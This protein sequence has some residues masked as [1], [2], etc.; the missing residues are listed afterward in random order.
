MMKFSIALLA[1]A[2]AL[3]IAPMARADTFDFTFNGGGYSASGEFTTTLTGSPYTVTGVTG[4]ADGYSI[5]GLSS[6]A[7]ADQLLYFPATDGYYADFGGI[8]FANANGVDYNITNYPSGSSNFINVS[9]LDL[10][11]YGAS[12]IPV[13]M[14]VTAT[15]EPSS[16][17]FMGTGLLGL[18]V[19]LYRKNKPSNLVLHS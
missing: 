12:A 4:T 17:L 7:S 18:A 19:V 11:G 5:T 9:T 15:P 16:L 1:L 6:Y 14:S 8:S 13:E 10:G 2:T 3:A